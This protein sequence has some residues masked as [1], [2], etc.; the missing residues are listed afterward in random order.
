MA[1]ADAYQA[2]GILT[3]KFYAD[4]LHIALAT[5][6]EVDLLVSWNFRHI[7]HYDKIRL[8]TAVNLERGYKPLAIYSPAR[9]Q[10][11]KTTTIKAVEMV[12][13]IRDAHYEQLR[14]KSPEERIAF[15]GA[16]A[17]FAG[18]DRRE[19][20]EQPTN[21]LQ[22]TDRRS[23]PSKTVSSRLGHCAVGSVGTV[24]RRG[25]GSW[26]GG[27]LSGRGLTLGSSRWLPR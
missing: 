22:P 17:R 3:P 18:G 19:R 1:L 4:G 5:S 10:T 9:W 25:W 2:H 11:M 13:R 27:R 7:V 8:F 6:A 20:Q 12:R 24:R 26:R 16:K 21:E 23:Q 14:G 15:Y